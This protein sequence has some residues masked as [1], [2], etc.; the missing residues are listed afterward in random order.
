MAKAFSA[1]LLSK[2]AEGERAFPD[3]PGSCP[4]I[5]LDSLHGGVYTMSVVGKNGV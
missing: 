3:P 1:S 2:T 4:S 5:K